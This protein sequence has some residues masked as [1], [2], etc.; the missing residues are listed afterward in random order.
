MRS[1]C[2]AAVLCT[3]GPAS[4]RTA[5]RTVEGV[6]VRGWTSSDAPAESWKGFA[7]FSL[8]YHFAGN[9]Q[10]LIQNFVTSSKM[11]SSSISKMHRIFQKIRQFFCGNWHPAG[12][13]GSRR[14]GRLPNLPVSAGFRLPGRSTFLFG[15]TQPLK[16]T[17]RSPLRPQTCG[18]GEFMLIRQKDFAIIIDILTAV[19]TIPNSLEGFTVP[20]DRI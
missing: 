20:V 14:K 6:L 11:P 3:G 12:C 16:N 7:A 13:P 1:L 18:A 8:F 9:I 19:F 5:G 15:S 4:G 2:L 17:A 10:A